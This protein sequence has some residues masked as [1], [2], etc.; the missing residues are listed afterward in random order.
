MSA[1]AEL[2]GRPCRARPDATA[3]HAAAGECL[4]RDVLRDRGFGCG[5]G[6]PVRGSPK[7]DSFLGV[8]GDAATNSCAFNVALAVALGS[9]LVTFVMTQDGPRTT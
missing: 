2:M 1:P 5:E 3:W 7:A 9:W 4:I 8:D 6:V